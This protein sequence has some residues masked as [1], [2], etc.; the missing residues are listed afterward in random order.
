MP[1]ISARAGHIG[2]GGGTK[3]HGHE[4]SEQGGADARGHEFLHVG[5]DVRYVSRV[6]ASCGLT[7]LPVRA[8]L[9]HSRAF[10]GHSCWF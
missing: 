5:L 7:G 1:T 9:G 2:A 4:K 8:F 10:L 3:G 6:A